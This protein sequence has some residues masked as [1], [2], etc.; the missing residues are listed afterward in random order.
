VGEP[1][2]ELT[3]AHFTFAGA[4]ALALA[5]L[6]HEALRDEMPR[7]TAGAVWCTACAPPIVAA[8]FVTHATVFQVGG[9]VVL[10]VGVW[11]TAVLNLRSASHSSERAP[12]R[13][14]LA[15]SGLAVWAPMVLAIDWAAAQHVSLPALSIPAMVAAHGVANAAGFTLCG[16]AGRLR[17]ASPPRP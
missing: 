9:A 8:G 14:L 7:L 5:W 13:V 12:R 3:A 4:G 11:S 1:I 6:G 15:V 2:V 17:W 16:L 10:T